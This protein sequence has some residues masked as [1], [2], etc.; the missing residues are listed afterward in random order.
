MGRRQAPQIGIPILS[1]HRKQYS[2]FYVMKFVKIELDCENVFVHI[3][4]NLKVENEY[5][6][7]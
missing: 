6:I 7:L 5:I 3:I 2:S 1:W 4:T